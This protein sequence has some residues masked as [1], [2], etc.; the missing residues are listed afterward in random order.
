MVAKYQRLPVEEQSSVIDFGSIYDYETKDDLN[1]DKPKYF[2]YAD[3]KNPYQSIHVY[4]KS[5]ADVEM[6]PFEKTLH[7]GCVMTCCAS[8]MTFLSYLLVFLTFP[9]SA[10]FCIKKV[11]EYERIVIYRLGRLLSVKRPGIVLVLPCLDKYTRV[12]VRTRAFSI[13]PLKV[14]TCDSGA[15]ELGAEVYFN[16]EDPV[17]S[18]GTVQ[19]LNYSMRTLAQTVLQRMLASMKLGEIEQEKHNITATFMSEL[20]SATKKWGT[21]II[22]IEMS[23]IKVIAEADPMTACLPGGGPNPIAMLQSLFLPPG[24]SNPSNSTQISMPPG[25]AN[26]MPPGMA[27]MIA[28]MGGQTGQAPPPSQAGEQQALLAGREKVS[29]SSVTPSDIIAMVKPHLG[30][31]LVQ[32]YGKIYRFIVKGED[33]GVYYMDLKNGLGSVGEGNPPGGKPDVTLS[34][35]QEDLEGLFKG[36]VNAFNAYM[37][38]RL[39]IDGDLKDAMA[40]QELIEKVKPV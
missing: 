16:I 24:A 35:T 17:L 4:N 31:H 39:Q 27:N 10:W 7:P 25:M 14:L 26:M 13:P 6:A 38:G 18:V 11:H 40:L 15:I 23:P 37:G 28:G 34:L 1:Q 2:S 8:T 20:N 21:N 32:E 9:V 22:K 36:E 19:D 29:G 33:G 30:A 3:I 12:D 5:K